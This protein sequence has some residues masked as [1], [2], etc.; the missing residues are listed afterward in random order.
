MS[1]EQQTSNS[2]VYEVQEGMDRD[3]NKQFRV[4]DTRT[5]SRFATCYVQSNADLVC[6]ALNAYTADEPSPRQDIARKLEEIRERAQFRGWADIGTS[7]VE[8]REF[9]LS[10]IYR[11]ENQ[12]RPAEPPSAWRPIETAP[13]LGKWVLLWWPDVTD[14]AFV[15]YCVDGQWRAATSGDRWP[16]L[17]GPTHWMPLPEGP[18]VTKDAP[19]PPPQPPP[20]RLIGE[21]APGFRPRDADEPPPQTSNSLV[22][23]H[24]AAAARKKLREQHAASGAAW[25]FEDW[26]TIRYEELRRRF[27]RACARI[28]ELESAADEPETAPQSPI[29]RGEDLSTPEHMQRFIERVLEQNGYALRGEHWVP[30]DH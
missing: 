14:A 8:D 4:T 18:S 28:T 11:L 21:Y 27:E 12:E 29:A 1:N 30:A 15:G 26:L 19:P 6:A 16:T 5:D 3:L 23:I 13:T 22:S 10:Y 9:L 17:P 7:A 20:K 24:D 2:A 25:S